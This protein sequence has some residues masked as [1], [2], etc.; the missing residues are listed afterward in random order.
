MKTK[1]P[2]SP[3]RKYG[4][5][6]RFPIIA[7]GWRDAE[8]LMRAGRYTLLKYA[9]GHGELL[10]SDSE[11]VFFLQKRSVFLLENAIHA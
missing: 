2:T 11:A 6:K 4:M 9:D 3:R 1:H 8:S 7:C 5:P 10:N